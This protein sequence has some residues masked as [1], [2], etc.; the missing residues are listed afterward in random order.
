MVR[1]TAGR[2][3]RAGDGAVIVG[4]E[5]DRGVA[6]LGE[7]RGVLRRLGEHAVEHDPILVEAL[8]LAHQRVE[9]V[10]RAAGRPASRGTRARPSGRRRPRD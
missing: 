5:A 10:E 8:A 6:E 4:D 1:G 3:E 9:F 2:A 7:R